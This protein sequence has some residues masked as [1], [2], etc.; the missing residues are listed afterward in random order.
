MSAEDI[1]LPLLLRTVLPVCMSLPFLVI[2][3]EKKMPRNQRRGYDCSFCG[4][5][6]DRV[7]RLVAGPGGVYIC[8]E[9]VARIAGESD[10]V[11]GAHAERCSFCSIT[12]S[13][14]RYI[15][16]GPGQAAICNECIALCQEIFAEE[17]RTRGWPRPKK[18]GDNPTPEHP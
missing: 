18:D 13:Q 17:V 10:E 8:N 6:Q 7:E 1:I 4:K 3:R 9:C 12:Q 11:R 5:N 2:G 16:R 15:K 14:T